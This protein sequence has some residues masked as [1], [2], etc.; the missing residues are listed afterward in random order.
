MRSIDWSKTPLGPIAGWSHALRTTGRPAAAQPLPD[1]ALVGARSSSSSTTTR[2]GRSRRQAPEVDGAAGGGVLGGDLAHHRADGR[3]A[4]PRRAGDLER[5]PRAAHRPPGASS[6]RRTSRSRTARSPT[7]PSQTRHRRRARDRRRDTRVVFGQRQLRTL[8]ELGESAAAAQTPEQAC[9]QGGGDA[10]RQPAR[11]PVRRLLLCW[12]TRPRGAPGR[13][14]GPGPSGDVAPPMVALDAPR[15]G[16]WR[17]VAERVARAVTGLRERFAALPSGAW[18][19][20]RTPRSRCRW[21][22][23]ISRARTA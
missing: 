20:R 18:R 14:R 8:R 12:T 16:R 22:R 13:A 3:S 9:A 6:R 2:T 15:S 7:R 4:V 21:R 11:R 17:G 19:S 5:R 10:G 23:P 1:A